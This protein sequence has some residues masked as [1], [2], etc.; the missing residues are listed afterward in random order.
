MT[1]IIQKTYYLKGGIIFYPCGGGL[2]AHCL[3][4]LREIFRSD[5]EFGSIE[6]YIAI[7]KAMLLSKI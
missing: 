5:A 1:P 7:G 3:T 2:I 6:G 4:Y